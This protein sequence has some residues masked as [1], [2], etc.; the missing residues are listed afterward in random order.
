MKR[1]LVYMHATLVAIDLA[2]FVVSGYTGLLGWAAVNAACG[3]IWYM[4]L[5][6]TEAPPNE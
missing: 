3:I 5:T 1:F 6:A 2:G 4:D